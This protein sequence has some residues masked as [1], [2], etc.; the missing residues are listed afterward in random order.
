MRAVLGLGFGDEGKGTVVDFLSNRESVNVRFS[1]TS[2]IGHTVYY[3]E[4]PHVFSSFGS[5][6]FKGASTVWTNVCPISVE[7]FLNERDKLIALI[8]T[9]PNYLI[10]QD[11][12]VITRY[13]RIINQRGVFL[14]HGTTG[15]GLAPTIKRQED[16]YSLTVRDLGFS[17]IWPHK[18]QAIADYHKIGNY[19]HKMYVQEL[20]ELIPHFL[21]SVSISDKLEMEFNH[22]IIFEGSQGLLL[23]P[24]IGFFPHVTR[25][26]VNLGD[27]TDYIDEVFLVTRAYSTRHGNG[28]FLPDSP[29]FEPLENIYETNKT[30][31]FQGKFR[32]APLSL[33]Y[34]KY[35]LSFVDKDIDHSIVITNMDAFNGKIPYYN[36][37]GE[38]AFAND[39][40]KFIVKIAGIHSFKHGYMNTSPH[41]STMK[42]IW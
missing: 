16:H 33:Q 28:P 10:S 36:E 37:E 15:T 39:P 1:G 26:E 30:N 8:G 11:S 21:S 6:T 5:G 25:M 34:L 29:A 3:G 42:Q 2:N 22:D 17:Q 19:E 35:A 24:N 4:T 12:P 40:T 38:L 32:K 14:E 23:D 20:K 13:D 27:I 7:D 9:L 31:P 18:L 41:S